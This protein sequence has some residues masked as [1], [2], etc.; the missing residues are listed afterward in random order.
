[1]LKRTRSKNDRRAVLIRLTPETA[2]LFEISERSL[3]QS[4]MGLHE[5]LGSEVLRQWH[6]TLVTAAGALRQVVGAKIPEDPEL[7]PE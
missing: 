3:L 7:P 4:F 5:S 1:M 6:D 2:S